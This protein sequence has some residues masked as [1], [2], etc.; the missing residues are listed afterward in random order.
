MEEELNRQ[1]SCCFTGH[2]PEKLI[3]S[4]SEIIPLLENAIDRAISNGFTTFITGM[5]RGTDIWAAKIV[6]ERKKSNPNLRLVCAVPFPG[7][8]RS[9]SFAET[10]EYKEVIDGSDEVSN[11]SRSFSAYCFQKRNAWMVDRSGLVIAVCS[12]VPS[13]TKNTIKYAERCGVGIENVLECC[14]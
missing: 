13:G 12:G 7:F 14:D 10:A 6:L 11:I 3:Q 9:R 1:H 4:K 5:A 8:E 2:R